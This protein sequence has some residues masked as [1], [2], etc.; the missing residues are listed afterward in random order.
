MTLPSP[1]E[2]PASFAGLNIAVVGLGIE[3]RDA[4]TFLEREGAGIITVDRNL[5]RAERHQDDLSIL[6]EVDGLIA[7]QGVHHHL[8]LLVEAARRDIPVYGPTQIFLERCPAPVIGITGSAG[9][10]T[11]TTLVHR[12]LQAAGVPCRLGG[13]I[14]QGL[15]GQ[16]PDITSTDMVVAEIS[17]T[18]LLRTTRSPHTAAITNITPNHLDQFS[19]EDYQQLK[20]RIVDYQSPS[21]VVVLPFND[22][23]AAAATARTDASQRW[24]GIGTPSM[25]WHCALRSSDGQILYNDRPL[26]SVKELKIPGEHNVLNAL[27]ALAIVADV[28]PGDIAT[29]V[30]RTFAGVPHRLELVAEI[31]CV[32]FINDSIAT[33]PERTLAGLKATAGPVV[34]MLGGRDKHLP[35]DPLIDELRRHVRLVVLFG[36]AAP[37]WTDRLTDRDIAA[38]DA[39]SFDAAFHRAATRARSGETVLM[40]PG[41]TSFDAYANF[42][43]RGQHFRDLVNEWARTGSLSDDH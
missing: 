18:Q 17:H 22:E 4:F 40:S 36:E 33:T 25:P 2:A 39:G 41:G 10:T 35:L 19:W 21:D 32:R 43:A 23:L 5:E 12:M 24:F 29:D 30:L 16:L 14:G 27:A 38:E 3:G 1:I 34:L 28:V 26:M 37:Q 13:N 20:Y 6:D 15:L 7:S 31:G 42:E 11:T 9:K 8:S